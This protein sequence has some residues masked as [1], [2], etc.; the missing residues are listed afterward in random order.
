MNNLYVKSMV[1][2]SYFRQCEFSAANDILPYVHPQLVNLTIRSTL[3]AQALYLLRA[4]TP[5]GRMPNL[6]S[7][8]IH[9]RSDSG[10]VLFLEYKPY[11]WYEDEEGPVSEVGGVNVEWVF[12][13]N[14][15]ATLAKAAPGLEELEPH[16]MISHPLFGNSPAFLR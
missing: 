3:C 11:T 12:D 16:R 9:I 10:F 5:G 1:E 2:I 4:V 6:K 15:L 8:G 14:Y 7:L 13:A